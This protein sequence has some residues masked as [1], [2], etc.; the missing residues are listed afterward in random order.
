MNKERVTRL[1]L[2]SEL[3]QELQ[4]NLP[5]PYETYSPIFKPSLG[6]AGNIGYYQLL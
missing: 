4:T 5:F 2:C 3:T 1:R 6:F